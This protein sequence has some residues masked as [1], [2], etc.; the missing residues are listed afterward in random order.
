MLGELSKV[1]TVTR[2]A[3]KYSDVNYVSKDCTPTPN[4][5]EAEVYKDIPYAFDTDKIV[6]VTITYEEQPYVVV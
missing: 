5:W 2:F 6:M 4:I 3:V 1:S